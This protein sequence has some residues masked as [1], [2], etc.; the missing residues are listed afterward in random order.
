MLVAL[1]ALASCI[2]LAFKR[3]NSRFHNTK[4]Q[5]QRVKREKSRFKTV[6]GWVGMKPTDSMCFSVMCIQNAQAVN[7]REAM[8]IVFNFANANYEV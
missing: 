2:A 3:T 7:H 6:I 1:V 5:Q 8:K 4:G